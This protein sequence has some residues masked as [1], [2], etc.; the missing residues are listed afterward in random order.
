MR[1]QPSLLRV[2][3]L[4]SV[5]LA[6]SFI[7][8]VF[9]RLPGI[10]QQHK[11]FA[12]VSHINTLH[13]TL[14]DALGTHLPLMPDRKSNNATVAGIDANTNG[15]R[16]D[17]ELEIFRAYPTAARLR[18]AE[19]Q[20][21]LA[22]QQ[23]V[24]QVFDKDTWRAAAQQEDRAYQCLGQTSSTTDRVK[25]LQ[26]LHL[27]SSEVRTLVLNTPARMDAYDVAATFTTDFGLPSGAVCD[28]DPLTLSN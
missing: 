24:T 13:I 21:A 5:G 9:Y 23:F 15:I 10:E 7:A 22:V 27:H 16:D 11:T 8:L 25:A 14:A 3:R 6:V 20:Y 4:L 17:V 18:S 28:I 1:I 19:L 2:F 12:A 26:E